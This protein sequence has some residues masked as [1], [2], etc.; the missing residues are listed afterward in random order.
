MNN[1]DYGFEEYIG[2]LREN[3]ANLA[4]YRERTG[5]V[6]LSVLHVQEALSNED[7]FVVFNASLA[8]TAVLA[9]RS[10]YH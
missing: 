8:A 2:Y 7:P 3:I 9:D 1:I 4:E 6:D 10:I 5:T